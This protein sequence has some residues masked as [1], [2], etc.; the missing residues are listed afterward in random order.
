MKIS[1]KSQ[2]SEPVFAPFPSLAVRACYVRLK[3][4]SRKGTGSDRSPF[5]LEIQRHSIGTRTVLRDSLK[6]LSAALFVALLLASTCS[7]AH[8]DN[9]GTSQPGFSG[10]RRVPELAR[11]RTTQS[12]K[13]PV[14]NRRIPQP[15]KPIASTGAE[16]SSAAES[17]S[18]LKTLAALLVVVSLILIGAK[19]LRKHS[20]ALKLGL[21]KD[22]VEVLGR[23]SLDPRQ[24]VYLVRLGGQILVLGSSAG[25]LRTLANIT[26]PVQ[27]DLLAGSCKQQAGRIQ[28]HGLV[29]LF[30]RFTTPTPAPVHTP[31][32][33]DASGSSDSE[34]HRKLQDRF[35]VPAPSQP[36]V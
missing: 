13:V 26:D 33:P 15:T 31:P 23:T 30:R 32:P 16:R 36:T 12:S 1:L 7:Q 6:Q 10:N 20:P 34:F 14:A 3:G 19:L 22:A 5:S 21:P 17:N 8:A 27:V 29:E 18:L 4:T 35:D 24:H 25:E 2:L 28:T 9:R 11:F